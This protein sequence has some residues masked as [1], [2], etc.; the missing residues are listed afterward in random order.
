MAM[1]SSVIMN[2]NKILKLYESLSSKPLGRWLFSKIIAFKVPYFGTI[3]STITV[4]EPNHCQCV[5]KKRRAVH[6][7]IKTVHAIA[8]CNGLE[9][10]MGM[11]AEASIPKHL[12]WL[13]KG[14]DVN[15]IAKAGSDIRCVAV[16]SEGV[17][18]PGDVVVDVAAYD[19][20]DVAVVTGQIKLWVSEKK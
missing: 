3:S 9:L 12:R 18:Q 15:Y 19:I 2:K 17:W 7:H 4:L 8:V 1:E 11:M 13:P 20:N 14:M 5:I 16:V 6:N 10:A